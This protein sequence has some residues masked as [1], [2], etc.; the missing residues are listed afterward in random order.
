MPL[1]KPSWFASGKIL[2]ST[3]PTCGLTKGGRTLPLVDPKTGLRVQE[4]DPETGELVDAVNDKLLEDMVALQSGKSTDTLRFIEREKVTLNHAVPV[5]YDRRYDDAFAAAMQTPEF[6]E[7]ESATLGD[8]VKSKTVT[9]RGGHGSPSA[10]QRVGDVPYIKVSDL[11]AGFV[12]I[13]P[14]NRVPHTIAEQHWRGKDSKL[15]AFDILCPERTSKN[16]G[17]FCVLMPGQERVMLTKEVIV[18]R[19]GEKANF[20]PF[21]IL[22]AMTLKIVRDQW[23]RVVFMQTNREDVGK[24]YFEIRIPVPP[25]REVA[26]RVSAPFREYYTTIA[27]A[28]SKLANYLSENGGHHFF[29]S[30]AEAP[31]PEEQ[32]AADVV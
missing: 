14:T 8:L 31:D 26:D 6:A 16:I 22:W 7:F 21:Y 11:R 5:Y 32:A 27:V 1:H 15:R 12:N 23:K 17:D 9:I 30:G 29:V 24:R 28:R 4:T 3:A 19:P 18:L 13:N 2:V 25:S 10:D 20:D